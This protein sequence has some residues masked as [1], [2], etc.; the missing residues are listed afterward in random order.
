V[1]GGSCWVKATSEQEQE[2]K[3]E[4]E[5]LYERREVGASFENIMV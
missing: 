2:L 4:Q 3:Q 5:V 1:I